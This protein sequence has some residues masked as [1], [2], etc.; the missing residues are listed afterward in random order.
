LGPFLIA[1]N[2]ALFPA[3]E[4]GVEAA[5]VLNTLDTGAPKAAKSDTTFRDGEGLL[6]ATGEIEGGVVGRRGI[7]EE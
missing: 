5:L 2:A 1:P 6:E 7:N 3:R 4:N